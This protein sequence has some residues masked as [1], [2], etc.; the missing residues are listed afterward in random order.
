MTAV[1]S[2][3]LRSLSKNKQLSNGASA[4]KPTTASKGCAKNV[5]TKGR[6]SARWRCIFY[7]SISLCIFDFLVTSIMKIDLDLWSSFYDWSQ[8]LNRSMGLRNDQ[9]NGILSYQIYYWL[10]SLR[11][12]TEQMLHHPSKLFDVL[13]FRKL[14]SSSED[15]PAEQA[16]SNADESEDMSETPLPAPQ[17]PRG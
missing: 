1:Y 14:S 12:S 9:N 17:L 6:I 11:L 15:D 4:S 5:G 2:E 13:V 8:I 7:Y 3:N 16:L 10:L